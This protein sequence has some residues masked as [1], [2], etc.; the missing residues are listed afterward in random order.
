MEVQK[1]YVKC[2]HC[3]KTDLL[4][5]EQRAPEPDDL[6]I[7]VD[8]ICQSCGEHSYLAIGVDEKGLFTEVQP[9]ENIRIKK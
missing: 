8:C 9:M 3:G 6:F 4:F 7:A 2:S 5:L 1:E